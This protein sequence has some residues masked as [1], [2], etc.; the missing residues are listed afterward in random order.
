MSIDTYLA[1][2]EALHRMAQVALT[3]AVNPIGA[4]LLRYFQVEC[5]A[6]DNERRVP[7]LDSVAGHFHAYLQ[8]LPPTAFARFRQRSVQMLQADPIFFR[9]LL[10][11][12]I[13]RE[14]TG[15]LNLMLSI[16]DRQTLRQALASLQPLLRPHTTTPRL[17]NAQWGIYVTLPR[18]DEKPLADSG[19]PTDVVGFGL[20]PTGQRVALTFGYVGASFQPPASNFSSG[21][22]RLVMF[23]LDEHIELGQAYCVM[24][25][26][27][28]AAAKSFATLLQQLL[29]HIH[30]QVMTAVFAAIDEETQGQHSAALMTLINLIV[31]DV[32][33]ALVQWL[34]ALFNNAD[35]LLGYQSWTCLLASEPV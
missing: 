32:F 23:D 3:P 13:Q 7:P 22:Q 19:A 35:E 1:S 9:L 11:R 30:H 8:Q 18:D 33:R 15:N 34:V 31:M 20:A 12:P 21:H 16:A 27:L 17:P 5:L 14:Q 24:A 28:A 2:V 6:A 25:V 10:L 4:A 29:P 26:S